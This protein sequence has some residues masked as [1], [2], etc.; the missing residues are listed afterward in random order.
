MIPLKLTVRNF[1]CYRDDVPPLDL[2]G[3]HVAC[4]CGDNG[5]GKSALLDAMTWAL[6]GEARARTQEELVHQGRSNM[7]VELDFKAREQ[8]YRVSRKYSRTARGSQST[9]LELQVLTGDGGRPI[10]GNTVRDTEARIRDLLHMDYVTLREHRV[11][12][13]GGAPTSSR[14][15]V[16][17]GARSVWQRCWTLP[18]TVG[19]RSGPGSAV[20]TP[21]A[22]FGRSREP[23]PHMRAQIGGRARVG[24]ALGRDRGGADTPATRSRATAVGGSSR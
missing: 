9:L 13:A 20:E 11:P 5:H 15:A 18:T 3:L 22:G 2:D 12:A 17:R 10:T 8:T 19:S 7:A 24:G 1:M 16:R 21:P 6:W 23:S 14:E 4:L